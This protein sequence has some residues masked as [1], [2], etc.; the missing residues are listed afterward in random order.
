MV[1]LRRENHSLWEV[2]HEHLGEASAEAC[3][4]DINLACL[5]QIDF[6]ASW[7]EVF[8]SAGFKLVTEADR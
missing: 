6:L 4:I 7:A 1:D 2:H 3:S 5:G 8:E